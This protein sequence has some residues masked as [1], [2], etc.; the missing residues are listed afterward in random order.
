MSVTCVRTISSILTGTSS[1]QED[2]IAG[3][4]MHWIWTSLC[5]LSDSGSC[6]R[7]IY[8]SSTPKLKT[9]IFGVLI[10]KVRFRSSICRA[11]W[12][13]CSDSIHE[14]GWPFI[15]GYLC[16]PP[17]CISN[18]WGYT[19]V[20]MST[21]CDQ[22]IHTDLPGCLNLLMKLYQLK[23]IN[24]LCTPHVSMQYCLFRLCTVW[25]H[26]SRFLGIC[27]FYRKRCAF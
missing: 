25:I 15:V 23:W 24:K 12:T 11:A 18:N 5:V 17:L 27:A 10:R 1:H 21:K 16:S 19:S 7:H 13:C 9:S 2:T 22:Y 6:W 3:Y 4:W 8:T 26:V 14:V 20:R